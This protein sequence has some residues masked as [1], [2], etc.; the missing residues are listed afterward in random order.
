MRSS[1]LWVAVI[2]ACYAPSLPEDVPCAESLACPDGQTCDLSRM[3]CS[4]SPGR[5]VDAGTDAPVVVVDP[6]EGDRDHDGVV[7]SKDN[8]PDIANP[9]Q[10]NEDGDKFG[11]ACDP[12]PAF[13]H[14][15]P[16]DPDGDGVSDECDPN[17]TTPG[18]TIELFEGFHNGLPSTWMRS[19]NWTAVGD[20][21]RGVAADSTNEYLVLPT[22][23]LDKLT[24][25]AS[26]TVEA[27]G[28][29]INDSH[30][31]DIAIPANLASLAGVNCE[32]QQGEPSGARSVKLRDD[33]TKLDLANTALNWSLNTA[34]AL[35]Y[36]RRGSNLSC[37]ERDA[38]G[39][40]LATPPGTSTSTATSARAIVRL[41]GVTSRV[42]WVMV[43][44]SP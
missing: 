20:S 24:A 2:S 4:S 1:L 16:S 14:D 31:V 19:T 25:S 5:G 23:N 33:F 36:T 22:T 35:S 44:R 12:C 8:C 17:P 11:D 30:D 40:S 9:D 10:A 28:S 43:V 42:N 15:V 26:F 7:D 39:G 29:G 38:G 27:V 37:I 41:Y 18:D 13:A 34:Y 21:V 6:P 3:T 32:L